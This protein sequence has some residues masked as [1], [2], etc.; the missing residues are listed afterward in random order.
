MSTL[1]YEI[2]SRLIGIN[3]S[4]RLISILRAIVMLNS[5]RLIFLF[6]LKADHQRQFQGI[7]HCANTTLVREARDPPPLLSQSRDTFDHCFNLYSES[8]SCCWSDPTT[9]FWNNVTRRF[10]N[11]LNLERAS[12]C[13]LC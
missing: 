3:N 12:R 1:A 9:L 2:L 4:R 10:V 11:S 6:F 13:F 7:P 5:C 8:R